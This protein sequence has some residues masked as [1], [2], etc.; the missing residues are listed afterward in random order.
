MNQDAFKKAYNNLNTEQ[1][2][3]VDTIEGPVMVNA[4]PGTGKTQILTLRIARILEQT[5]TK[6]EQILA[7]TFTNAGSFTM[8]ERLTQYVGDL[9]YR[10]NIYTF[11]SFCKQVIQNN[12]FYFPQ[13]EY[14]NV[15]DDLQKVKIIESILD[16]SHFTYLKG[17]HD[18]Y[19]KVKDITRAL[20]TIKKE[21]LSADQFAALIPKWKDE[22]YQD[23]NLYYKRKYKEYNAGD[24]K[25]Q[26]EQK[27]QRRIAQ[28]YELVDLY[29]QYQQQLSDLK[30]YDFSDMILTVLDRLRTDE[31]FKFDLQEQFQYV[32][33]DEHQDTNEG[34][35]ELIE[36]LTDAEHLNRRPNVFTVGDE[37]QSIYRFQGASEETFRHFNTLYDDIAHISLIQNYRS[38]KNILDASHAVITSSLEQSVAL[39]SNTLDNEP[40]HIGEFS[41]YKFELLYV[42]YDIQQKI[43]Q[44]V[45]PEHIAIL[46][47]ANKHLTD[48]KTVLSH[49]SIPFSVYS[50]D[51]VFEDVDISNIIKLLKVIINPV[52]E[53]QLSKALL[54]NFLGLDGHDVIKILDARSSYARSG[55]S[56]FDMLRDSVILGDIGLTHSDRVLEFSTL[57]T[58]SII[59][60]QN[61]HILDFLKS[62]LM[63]IGYTSYM[64]ASPMSRDKML[65]LDK[66]F[67][68]IKKQ[69]AKGAFKIQDFIKLVDS[70]HA[71]HLD[72][73][74]GSPDLK[75]GVQLMTAHGSKGKEFEH[76]YL[77]NTTRSHWENSRSFGG[78][79][80]PIQDYKGDVHDERRLFYVAMTRARRSLSITYSK[81]DWEG[82]E[83]EK[84]MFITE[85][86]SEC[87]VLIDV[88]TFEQS[89]ADDLIQFLVPSTQS[90]TIYDIEYISEIFMRRGLTVTGLNNYVTCPIKYFYRSLIQIPSGYSAILKYGN[91]VHGALEKFFARSA[92]TGE[93]ESIEVLCDLFSIEIERSGLRNED[94]QKYLARG[95]ENLGYW[96]K[97]RKQD[98]GVF[99]KLEEKVKRDFQIDDTTHICIHGILDKI[100][101]T[102]PQLEGGVTIVDYKTGKAYSHKNKE[103]RKD[104]ERQLI[105]Y[106]VLLEE[107][108]KDAWHVNSAMLDFIEPNDK[109]KSELHVLEVGP[110]QIQEMKELITRTAHEILSGEFLNKGCKKKDCEWCALHP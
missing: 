70:Y 95:L 108:Q 23:E 63:N 7:L 73:E 48:L 92:Q 36:L 72:I 94:Y 100:E 49:A 75:T 15:I 103:Q 67:D 60:I 41:N 54:I 45:A 27:I 80:L 61:E 109:G 39:T 34:Q 90:K 56:L 65:K 44:G 6:P 76:V 3:A 16:Q 20:N 88:A 81:T 74:S 96:Y 21:G 77:I 42:A 33:V 22:L 87:S 25:P 78:I 99:V 35:N 13:F 93:L 69:D 110:A 79:A 40:I 102:N 86:L 66:L 101:F 84:S 55:T 52:D 97:N 46:Y 10:V 38:T 104:L 71:Y 11:H 59:A 26:E 47:R 89:H 1:R 82:R 37:K 18:E 32:L 29:R 14:A 50:K 62:F 64:L 57:L 105:F 107:Y 31:N 98:L 19:Q 53:E 83:Q 17:S 12:S 28:G 4:G 2:Q 8:R 58:Q 91:A 51:S 5:D 85:I 68:E 24:I 30:L 43:A 9:A 106:Y